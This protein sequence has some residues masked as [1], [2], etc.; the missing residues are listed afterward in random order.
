MTNFL[1]RLAGR[2]LG[3]T[4]VAQPIIPARFTPTA[5]RRGQ[6]EM[7][8]A[9]RTGSSI[10]ERSSART[11][12]TFR[13]HENEA[14]PPVVAELR[15]PTLPRT[16]GEEEV[17]RQDSIPHLPVTTE[18]NSFRHP[19]SAESSAAPKDPGRRPQYQHAADATAEHRPS[20]QMPIRREMLRAEITE[21]SSLRDQRILHD[22]LDDR[23]RSVIAR[24]MRNRVQR[25]I[26]LVPEQNSSSTPPVIRVTIG[27]IDVR[28]ELTSPPSSTI[29]RS[30]RP[31]TLSLDQYLKRQGEA[32]R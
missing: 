10:D 24:P 6:L 1:D 11:R 2:A 18:V 4:P 22:M 13:L 30:N 20:E 21:S 5:E 9:E 27:R 15:E 8:D 26:D 31:S 32:G 29:A 14:S 23:G 7:T 17:T 19:R 3:V 28:A 25:P 12:D 16:Q